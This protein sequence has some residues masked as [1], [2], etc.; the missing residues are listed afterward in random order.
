MKR[1]IMEETLMFRLDLSKVS[2]QRKRQLLQSCIYDLPLYLTNEE[3]KLLKKDRVPKVSNILW[4]K[5][6]VDENSVVTDLLIYK[7]EEAQNLLARRIKL[8]N[9]V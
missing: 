3:V 5:L 4:Y 1:N 9:A 2:P 8:R 6:I 7:G